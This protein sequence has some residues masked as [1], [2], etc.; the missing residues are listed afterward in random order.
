MCFN[1][2]KYTNI[3]TRSIP[4]ISLFSLEFYVYVQIN[5]NKSLYI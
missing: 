1:L 5:D 2:N 3:D 4:N